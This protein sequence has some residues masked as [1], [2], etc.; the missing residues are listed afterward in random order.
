VTGAGGV[1]KSFRH[2]G[3]KKMFEG[4][5]SRVAADLRLRVALALSALDAAESPLELNVPGYRLHQLKGRQKGIW[6]I[7]VSGNWRIT[8][9]FEEGDAR[10]VDLIDYH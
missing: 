1:I 3:L 7:T 10:D 2:S 8:F 6:S 9:R 4:N 5:A